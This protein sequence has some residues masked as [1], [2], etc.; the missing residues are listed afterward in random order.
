[1]KMKTTVRILE[2]PI[3]LFY[4]SGLE[5]LPTLII[6]LLKLATLTLDP[7]VELQLIA[8]Q[9]GILRR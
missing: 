7:K 3:S 4:Q 6:P 2:F 9:H 5:S 8:E 1:M